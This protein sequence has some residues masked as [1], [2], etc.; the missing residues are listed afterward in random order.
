MYRCPCVSQNHSVQT[1]LQDSRTGNIQISGHFR[2]ALLGY[3]GCTH[4]TA[5]V[6]CS[7]ETLITIDFRNVHVFW[8]SDSFFFVK[9]AGALCW[10]NSTILRQIC[11]SR[12]YLKKWLWAPEDF[13]VPAIYGYQGCLWAS[14][15]GYKICTA[16][17]IYKPPRKVQASLLTV[18]M[19]RFRLLRL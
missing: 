18:W 15:I 13:H 11:P 9:T 17:V 5:D 2:C 19:R 14:G 1:F 4:H 3:F 7:L 16:E 10:P 8:G 6:R 12:Y